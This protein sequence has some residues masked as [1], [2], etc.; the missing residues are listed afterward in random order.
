MNA[1]IEQIGGGGV[2]EVVDPDS[3]ECGLIEGSMEPLRRPGALCW[4]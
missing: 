2:P 3:W 1:A 4:E